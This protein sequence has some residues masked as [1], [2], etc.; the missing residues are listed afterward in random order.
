[1]QPRQSRTESRRW[2]QLTGNKR[3]TVAV[4]C[5]TTNGYSTKVV[6]AHW[7]P[8]DSIFV[9]YLLILCFRSC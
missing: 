7:F 6:C 4:F 9:V 5:G 3:T 8:F 1:M 2:A